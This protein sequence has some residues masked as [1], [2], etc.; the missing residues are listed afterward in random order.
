MVSVKS[1]NNNKCKHSQKDET[2]LDETKETKNWLVRH[3]EAE[4]KKTS[5]PTLTA[6][7]TSL[8]L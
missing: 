6:S 2:I 7:E 1:H 4:A 8:D 5:S 3:A